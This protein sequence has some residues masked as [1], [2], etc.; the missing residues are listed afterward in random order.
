MVSRLSLWVNGEPIPV[1]DFVQ[2]F[3]RNVIT[4]MLSVLKGTEVMQTI[5]LAI[6]EDTVDINVNN[7]PVPANPFVRSFIRNT[8]LGMVSSL[9]G[10]GK[11]EELEISIMD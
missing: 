11:I 8:V 6:K 9:K 3:L 1:D 4:G 2:E 10:V 7:T 5:K